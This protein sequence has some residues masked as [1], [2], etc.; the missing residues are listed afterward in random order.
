MEC[1][2]FQE[3][4]VIPP[5]ASVATDHR[6]QELLGARDWAMLPAAVRARFSK[7]LRGGESTAYQGVVTVMRMNRAGWVLSQMARLVGAPFPFDRSCVNRPAAVVVTEDVSSD[8]QFWIRQYGRKQGFPQVVH[9]SKRFAG[10][11]GLEEYIGYGIGMALQI[12]ATA[13]A[14]LFKS[15]HFFVQFAGRR[16]QLPRWMNPGHVVVGH[17][18][19]GNARFRFSL[20]VTH[21]VFGVMLR[22]DAIFRDVS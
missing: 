10:P 7:R 1:I 21:R 20:T 5:V 4:N 13:H 9:S 3:C 2:R 8:G 18:D 6:F 11:T 16:W 14:L 12:E 15:D 22:Q 17:H 19:M